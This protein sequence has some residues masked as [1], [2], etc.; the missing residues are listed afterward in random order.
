[1]RAARTRSTGR[2]PATATSTL[3]GPRRTA[4][5]PTGHAAAATGAAI[6][7]GAAL[8]AV[9]GLITVRSANRMARQD[10]VR[11]EIPLGT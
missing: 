4:A 11:E 5:S 3:G 8:G 1:M 9:D 6:I 2:D 7:A 10:T